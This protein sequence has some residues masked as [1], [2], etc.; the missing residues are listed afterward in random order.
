MS[1]SAELQAVR[2][3]SEASWAE[4]SAVFGTALPLIETVDL[5]GLARR[6]ER[7]PHQRQYLNEGHQ[8][9]LMPWDGARI[10]LRGRLTGLGASAAGA[11][12]SS[13]LVTLLGRL[14]GASLNGLAVG[15][16]F[17]G[18][19]AAAPATSM[20][21]GIAAGALVRGGQVGDGRVGGQFFPVESHAG[22]AIVP[23]I[24]LPGAPAADDVLYASKMVHPNESGGLAEVVES[25]RLQVL[26]SNGHYNLHGCFPL[27]GPRITGTSPGEIPMWE[28][29]IGVSAVEATSDTF[30]TAT[31]AQRH[32]SAPVVNGSWAIAQFGDSTREE[33]VVRSFSVTTDIVAEGLRGPGGVFAGQLIQGACRRSAGCSVELVIDA[34]ATGTYTWA[35][36]FAADPNTAPYWQLCASL[37]CADGRAVGMYFPRLVLTEEEPITMNDGGYNRIR[38]RFRAT[39]NLGGATELERSAFRIAHA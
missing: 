29:D 6:K 27:G 30:P 35:E 32:A 4:D 21:A 5:T 8:D 23:L 19:T 26:T 17:T 34:P 12:P 36:R 7:H 37:S 16:T 1:N 3:N 10:T 31:V 39:A 25:F 11:V 22:S 13:D 20:A 38:L 28:A 9:I 18:G 15:G 14:I 24:D 2:Y 33:L